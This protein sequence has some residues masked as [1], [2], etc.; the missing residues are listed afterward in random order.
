M[1]TS[2]LEESLIFAIRV[3]NFFLLFLLHDYFTNC[4][5]STIAMPSQ[6]PSI[7]IPSEKSPEFQTS[8]TCKNYVQLAKPLTEARA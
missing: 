5:Q 7:Y 6:G 1:L 8:H 2:K 3:L 4:N